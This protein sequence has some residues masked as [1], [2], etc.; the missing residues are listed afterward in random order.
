LEISKRIERISFDDLSFSFGSSHKPLFIG[1]DFEFQKGESYWI[2]GIPGS[3]KSTLLK[4]LVGLVEA[5]AGDM[6]IN[7]DGFRQMSFEEFLPYRRQIG[8]SFDLG[9]LIS[10]CTLFD[11]LMLPLTYHHFMPPEEA[12][13]WVHQLAEDFEISPV[14]HLRPSRVSGSNKKATIVARSL[15][16]KP[17]V[18]LLDDPTTGISGSRVS[19]LAEVIHEGRM[20]GQIDFVIFVS[21]DMP[22]VRKIATRTIEIK[23]QRIHQTETVQ[24]GFIIVE[25]KRAT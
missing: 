22:F 6:T 17:R 5:T 8:Y 19:K 16:M 21:E 1:M 10:N 4:L 9:G 24:S 7:R 25:K 15:V 13:S 14:L 20:N 3:G 12:R 2:K 11:N 18:L 23:D